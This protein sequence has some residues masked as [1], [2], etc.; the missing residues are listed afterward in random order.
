MLSALK[1]EA[2]FNDR[3]E[4]VLVSFSSSFFVRL[5]LFDASSEVF[6]PRS[7]HPRAI[8]SPT[9]KK[10]INLVKKYALC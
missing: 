6:V 2:Y 3:T 8:L 7:L 9:E 4:K 10:I 5:L 1:R